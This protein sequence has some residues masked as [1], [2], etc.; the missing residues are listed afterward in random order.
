MLPFGFLNFGNPISTITNAMWSAPSEN[1]PPPPYSKHDSRTRS[2]AQQTQSSSMN[3]SN[4][5]SGGAT[6]THGLLGGGLLGLL[7][8]RRWG[9]RTA[10]ATERSQ[11]RVADPSASYEREVLRHRHSRH[12]H[13]PPRT[14]ESE[15]AHSPPPSSQPVSVGYARTERR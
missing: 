9:A 6:F 2:A 7:L 15:R 4:D 13:S 8:G 5:N 12:H 11:A 3:A 1:I 10:E 14:F